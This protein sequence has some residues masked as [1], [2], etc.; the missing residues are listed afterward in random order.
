MGSNANAQQAPMQWPRDILKIKLSKAE[1]F[2]HSNL[3]NE[4]M[5]YE[6]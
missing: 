2:F 5:K 1:S 3:F 6:T 4:M